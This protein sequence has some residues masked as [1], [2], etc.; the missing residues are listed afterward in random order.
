MNDKKTERNLEHLTEAQFHIT[1][2]AGTEPAFTGEYWDSKD[3]GMYKCVVCGENLFSSESKFDSRTGWPS[4]SQE[5][6]S[7]KTERRTDSSHGMLR[8]EVV[9]KSCGAH[10]GHVF[11]DGP[12][13]NGDRYCINS[14]ALNLE[15]KK[16]S[17]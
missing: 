15:H 11:N 17:N 2:E 4:F 7:G 3:E 6:E 10:L 13:P 16:Q 1:Q 5:A 14:A 12:S 9:C 8:E